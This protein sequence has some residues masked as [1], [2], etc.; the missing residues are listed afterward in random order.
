MNGASAFHGSIW[1]RGLDRVFP[2]PQNE[3]GRKVIVRIESG[4]FRG[5]RD[6]RDLGVAVMAV[7]LNYRTID[8][9]A[10]AARVPVG[11]WHRDDGWVRNVLLQN[12]DALRALYFTGGEPMLEN[13]VE[14]I[15]THLI[16]RGAAE[17]VDIEMNSNC[18]VVR[19]SVVEKLQR[20]R[21][22]TI[23]LSIDARGAEYEYIRY[24]AR[25]DTVRRNVD[26]LMALTG[27]RFSL[28]GGI[29]LQ[30]YNALKL[31]PVLEF[32]DERRVPYSIEIA[33]W[34]Q[35]LAIEVLPKRVREVAAARLDAYATGSCRP[36]QQELVRTISSRLRACPDRSTPENLRTLMLFTNDLDVTRSQSVRHV[37]AELI[38]LLREDGFHWTDE[39]SLAPAA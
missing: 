35:F 21:S 17:H 5:K 22:V 30:V 3:A 19:D 7:D 26:R 4:T 16:E 20:F 38:E 34:P 2:V 37:H 24:P 23:G 11:P 14:Q 10:A 15:L 25:W 28:V 12:A 13:Q 9:D 29:V 18:T 6:P 27:P 39:P 31:T 33:A 8:V 32:F 1:L 36:E